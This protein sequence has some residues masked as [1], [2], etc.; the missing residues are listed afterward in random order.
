MVEG[1]KGASVSTVFIIQSLGFVSGFHTVIVSAERPVFIF[2]DGLLVF[3]AS[4]FCVHRIF[5]G[6]KPNRGSL[7]RF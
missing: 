6:W 3:S 1:G 5:F 7:S 2:S 4:R